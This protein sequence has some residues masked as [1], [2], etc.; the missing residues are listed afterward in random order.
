M[1][2]IRRA[3]ALG[4]HPDDVELQAGGALAAWAARGAHVE[5][6]CFTAGE[7]GSSDPAAKQAELAGVRRA[8]A[9]AAARAWGRRSRSTS[10]GRSTAS[11]RP[12][13]PCAW[14]CP[15]GPVGR[16]R[17]P[18]HDPCGAGC[19]TPTTGRRC[20]PCSDSPPRPAY[21]LLTGTP[22]GSPAPAAPSPPRA[23][24]PPPQRCCCSSRSRRA[25]DV[26]ATRT[27]SCR[28]FRPRQQFPDRRTWNG[29]S[30]PGSR[31]VADAGLPYA[32]PSPP[33][34]RGC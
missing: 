23:W 33:S 20:S 13:W 10:W 25:V 9:E 11:W 22:G 29:G 28:R 5:L 26:T 8:E 32:R 34:P 24:P 18:G 3:L 4:A 30:V 1:L 16:P 12:P 2:A 19:S 6:A 31:I 15:S 21:G 14:P 27:P 17:C 7:K